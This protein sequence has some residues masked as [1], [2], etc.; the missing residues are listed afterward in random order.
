V[1]QVETQ[2]QL[3]ILRVLGVDKVQ[4]Y[5][6]GH[7]TADPDLTPQPSLRANQM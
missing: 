1:E 3:D 5:L 2:A 7:P 6:L 4:G